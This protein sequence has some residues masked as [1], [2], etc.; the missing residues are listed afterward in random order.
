MSIDNDGDSPL[1]YAVIDLSQALS[2]R[3]GRQMNQNMIYK[4]NYVRVDLENR[5]DTLDN[6][7][8]I[9]LGGK[10]EYYSP[11]HHRCT[12]LKMAIASERARESTEIDLD[13][14]PNLS[15]ERDYSGVRFGWNADSD[16]AFQTAESFSGLV[17]THWDLEDVF[18]AY[19]VMEGPP[20]QANALWNNRCGYVNNFGFAASYLNNQID[21]DGVNAEVSHQTHTPYELNLPEGKE[22]SVLNGLMG[23][24]LFSCST[25]EFSISLLDGTLDSSDDYYVR[26]TVGVSGWEVY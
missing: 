9:T 7:A 8:G 25:D 26:I 23:V 16:V 18:T 11:S 6:N 19:N 2:Q 22:L 17:G 13:S 15:L 1:G 20:T 3:L 21:T 10:I 14:F 5:D 12:A 4:V 24:N